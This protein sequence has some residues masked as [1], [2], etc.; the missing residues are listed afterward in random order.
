M[1]FLFLI[2]PVAVLAIILLWM[3][4]R[5][6]EQCEKIDTG[7]ELCYWKLSYRRKFI[8][9]LWM[10]P[11]S[12]IIIICLHTKFQS[13]IGTYLLTTIFS[14]L[15]LIQAVYNYKKWKREEAA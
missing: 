8:R 2:L 12:I 13:D 6:W 15:L 9:T 5:K 4:P 11:I 10:I 1:E 7:I 3:P 14:I